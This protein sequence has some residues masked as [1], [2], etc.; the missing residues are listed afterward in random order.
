[1]KRRRRH[2]P[3]FTLFEMLVTISI[4]AIVVV[5]VAPRSG[6]N[7]RLRVMAASTIITSDLE[8]AQVMTIAHPDRPVVVRFEPSKEQYWLAYA[9]APDTPITREETGEDYIVTL[10]QGRASSAAGVDII[11]HNAP[12]KTIT[13]NA[14]G[15]LENFIADIRIKLT[16]DGEQINLDLS[17]ATGRVTETLK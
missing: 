1:M 11:V 3:G 14:Q 12:D 7:A 5:A 15:G 16:L 17:P 10:G 4:I 13:Y 9:D 6:N 2:G 8:L